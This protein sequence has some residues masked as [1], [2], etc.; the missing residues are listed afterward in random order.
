MPKGLC[1]G[2]HLFV[3]S[4][5]FTFLISFSIKGFIQQRLSD[6]GYNVFFTTS[7]HTWRY[8]VFT[9]FHGPDV[10][11]AFLAHLRKQFTYNGITM[12]DDQGIERSQIIA[13]ALTKAISH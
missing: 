8:N 4:N 3:C 1:T 2:A 7:P 12:F 11:K 13:S 6:P 5:K 10:R 9:S